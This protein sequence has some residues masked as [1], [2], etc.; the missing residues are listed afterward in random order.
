MGLSEGEVHGK[1]MI[2]R[3]AEEERDGGSLIENAMHQIGI[4]E[5]LDKIQN[6][7][8]YG[9]SREKQLFNVSLELSI[10]WLNR[11]LFLKLLEAQIVAFHKDDENSDFLNIHKVRSFTDL[12]NLFFDVLAHRPLDRHP[13]MQRQF[14]L[15]PYLTCSL[16][17]P[18]GLERE[19]III[20]DLSE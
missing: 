18:S 4:L 10:T 13:E 17:V 11:I 20:G 16:F 14:P 8:N 5:K 3:R 2:G 19:F 1:K 15:I 12:N 6:V 9:S 7:K